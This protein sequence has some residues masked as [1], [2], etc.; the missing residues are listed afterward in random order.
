VELYLQSPITPSWRG[1]QLK[2]KHSGN[3]I[4]SFTFTYL[5]GDFHA[6]IVHLEDQEEKGD[7]IKII[8]VGYEGGRR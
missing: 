8:Y 4:Y 2:K 6:E 5:S 7:N 3:F 1:A